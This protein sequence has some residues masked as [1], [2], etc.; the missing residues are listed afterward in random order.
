MQ[1]ILLLVIAGV[2][3]AAFGT[4]FMGNVIDLSMVQDFGVGEATIQSQVQTAYIDF[5]IE[6]VIGIGDDGD[7]NTINVFKNDFHL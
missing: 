2:G 6:K 4:G 5:K 7:G 1:P 3:V